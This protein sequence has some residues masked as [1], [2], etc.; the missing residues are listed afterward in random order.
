MTLNFLFNQIIQLIWPN[1][2]RLNMKKYFSIPILFNV[3]QWLE[4]NFCNDEIYDL[5]YGICMMFTR[6]RYFYWVS[7]TSTSSQYP[8]EHQKYVY[9]KAAPGQW[10]NQ[11]LHWGSP[12]LWLWGGEVKHKPLSEQLSLHTQSS[13][14][15]YSQQTLYS[16][17]IRGVSIR[18]TDT[19]HMGFLFWVHNLIYFFLLSCFI[20][21]L[22]MLV[23]IIINSITIILIICFNTIVIRNDVCEN[24]SFCKIYTVIAKYIIIPLDNLKLN[25]VYFP[26][27]CF[28]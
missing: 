15:K 18:I 25:K 28:L 16:S 8:P 10:I 3:H 20:S 9:V 22:V 21:Y 12:H 6:F 19:K 27:S 14:S 11:W 24:K 5:I 26:F 17:L 2:L 23:H 1:E 13:F 4:Q 7:P